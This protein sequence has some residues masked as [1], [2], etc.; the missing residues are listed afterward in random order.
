MSGWGF[1]AQ[2]ACSSVSLV[3]AQHW[4]FDNAAAGLVVLIVGGGD[5]RG[6]CVGHVGIGCRSGIYPNVV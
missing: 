2:S 5:G 1:L 3:G 6:G 4:S